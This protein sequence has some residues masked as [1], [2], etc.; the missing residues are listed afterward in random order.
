MFKISYRKIR[1]SSQ[2]ALNVQWVQC[3]TKFKVG[4]GNVPN[5][6][7]FFLVYSIL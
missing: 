6:N 2:E 7:P 5:K 3:G 1:K 4:K